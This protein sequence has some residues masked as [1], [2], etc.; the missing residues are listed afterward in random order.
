MPQDRWGQP[1]CPVFGIVGKDYTPLQNHQA[2]AFFDPIVGQGEAIYHTAGALGMGER[3]WLLAK[4][5]T[6]IRVIG[7]ESPTSTCS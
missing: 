1:D 7:D 2:F 6:D 4:L 5:P 3:I